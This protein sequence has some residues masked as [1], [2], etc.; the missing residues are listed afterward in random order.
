MFDTWALDASSIERGLPATFCPITEDGE[1]VDGM[2]YI[3]SPPGKI[4]GV[5]HPNGQD[6]A[7]KFCDENYE[8]L[9]AMFD[10]HN[11]STPNAAEEEGNA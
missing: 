2:N 8:K 11:E 5:F 1:I 3:G 6:A 10:Q 4:V 7:D 9:Q